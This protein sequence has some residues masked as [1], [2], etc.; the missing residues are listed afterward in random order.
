MIF[1]TV[2]DMNDSMSDITIDDKQYRIR[3]TYN[4]KFEY[5]SFGLYDTENKPIIAMTRI[6]PN[7]PINQFLRIKNAPKGVFGAMSDKKV[8]GR[9]SFKDLEAEFVY[10]TAE[11]LEGNN[12]VDG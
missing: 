4:T 9:Q 2:P 8:I 10:I 11:E 5:W 7:F 3:F 6:V 12:N 1:I